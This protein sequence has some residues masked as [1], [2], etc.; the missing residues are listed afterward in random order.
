MT[1]LLVCQGAILERLMSIL[2]KILEGIREI[3][4]KNK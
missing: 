4:E 3:A 1:F 2:N